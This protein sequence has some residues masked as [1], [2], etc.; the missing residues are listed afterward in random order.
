MFNLEAL[1]ILTLVLHL[2]AIVIIL[3]LIW[4]S[5]QRL[6]GFC[7]ATPVFLQ[8][9][10][11]I[12]DVFHLET[13]ALTATYGFIISLSLLIAAY[14]AAQIVRRYVINQK[15]IKQLV[16]EKLQQAED[17]Y[18]LVFNHSPLG[19]FY[20]DHEGKITLCNDN[21]ARIIGSSCDVTADVLCV[22]EGK[23]EQ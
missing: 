8:F 18:R 11:R 16:G 1:A 4:R 14:Y 5:G 12:I 19:I 23:S 3:H 21:F 7:I 22:H 6:A 17:K 13:P 20:F 10:R 9:I 15:I 2:I